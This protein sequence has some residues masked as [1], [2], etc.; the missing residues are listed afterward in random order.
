MDR[1]LSKRFDEDLLNLQ[2]MIAEMGKLTERQFTLVHDF[3]RGKTSIET[4]ESIDEI[5]I[6]VN[7][8]HKD[9]NKEC[10]RLTAT[11]APVAND[12]R[13]LSA[14]DRI[15]TDFERIGDEVVKIGRFLREDGIDTHSKLWQE[16]LST[17]RFA[18]SILSRTINIIAR[19]D[20]NEA[21]KLLADDREL[22][23][24][25]ASVTRQL[26]TYMM[27][28]PRYI[29]QAVN[30][31]F[32]AKALERVGDHSINIAEAIIFYDK[33]HDVRHKSPEEIAALFS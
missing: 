31:L 9:I 25:Y 21:I 2:N 16:I 32:A 23:A 26:I 10:V 3:L 1:H 13:F 20:I 17:A 6:K 7:Q 14:T 30:V 5:D 4:L 8:F 11:R 29:S 27:E 15:A 22:D 24:N 33:G 28:D 18:H 19:I 12:L